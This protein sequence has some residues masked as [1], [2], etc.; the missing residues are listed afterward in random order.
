MIDVSAIRYDLRAVLPSGEEMSLAPVTE[1]LQWEEQ[2]GEAAV[3]LTANLGDVKTSRG[4]V[5]DL[6]PLAGRVALYSDWGAGWNAIMSGSVWEWDS[7]DSGKDSL[8]ITAYDDLMYLQKSDD[9]MLVPAGVTGWTV[10]LQIA[11]RWGLTFE[12]FQAPKCTLP[13]MV[14]QG[15]VMEMIR[16]VFRRAELAGEWGLMLRAI[17]A[18]IVVTLPAQ[19]SPIYR[20][21]ASR[22]VSSYREKMDMQ[23]LVT[24]VRIV[25]EAAEP[26]DIAS[27]APIRPPLE[28]VTQG[29]MRF[30]KL[31]QIIKDQGAGSPGANELAA[32]QLLDERGGPKRDITLVAPDLPFLRR[33]DQL[34]ACAGNLDRAVLIAGVQHNADNRT[35]TVSI[36]LSGR[37]EHRVKF[38]D[39]DATAA[40]IGAAIPAAEGAAPT[41]DLEQGPYQ[42]DPALGLTK[43][44]AD[45]ACGPVAVV[46]F[47]RMLGRTTPTVRT[48]LITARD[49]GWWTA[50]DGMMGLAAE[51]KLMARFNIPT[52]MIETGNWNAVIAEVTAGRPVAISTPGHYFV[53]TGYNT[54]TR[55]FG[56][57]ETG[58]AGNGTEWMTAAEMESLQGG[59]GGFL[60]LDR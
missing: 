46:A 33:G 49:F 10:L 15:N 38:L 16:A 22:N 2:P 14:M 58:R 11:D 50:A 25:G 21:E 12:G 53:A 23:D 7:A 19:N 26:P 55:K 31:R 20:F 39:E 27:D 42:F 45:A 24:E 5:R 54:A 57:G 56:L 34:Y 48:A 3:R 18:G 51:N 9:E 60:V 1:G 32:R 17:P 59:L 36:D 28:G 52:T 4:W 43:A 41:T 29:D 35:M 30:G 47:A 40:T 44:E 37:A 13:K 6:V 8:T